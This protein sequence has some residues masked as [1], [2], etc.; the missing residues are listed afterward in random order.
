M[1]RLMAAKQEKKDEAEAQVNGG[2]G[3]E[4]GGGGRIHPA[5]RR[6]EVKDGRTPKAWTGTGCWYKLLNCAMSQRIWNL[7][8][9]WVFSQRQHFPDLPAFLTAQTVP[10]A[11]R[12]DL[13][14]SGLFSVAECNPCTINHLS[15]CLSRRIKKKKKS[16]KRVGSAIMMPAAFA[17]GLYSIPSTHIEPHTTT[18]NS[19]SKRSMAL[20]S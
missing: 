18:C 2:G 1:C 15:P 9:C 14:R 11:L 4:G 20:A 10:L 8:I 13:W 6:A 17:E 19:S 3:R 12:P 7:T 5:R 16:M